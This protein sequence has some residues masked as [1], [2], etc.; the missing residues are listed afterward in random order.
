MLDFIHA[1][2]ESPI[3]QVQTDEWLLKYDPSIPPI[4]Y[5]AYSCLGEI[6]NFKTWNEANAW[7]VAEILSTLKATP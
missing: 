7:R 1:L 6:R 2:N 4:S 3:M 5:E